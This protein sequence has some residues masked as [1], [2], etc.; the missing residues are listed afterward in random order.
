MGWSVGERSQFSRWCT[1]KLTTL[2]NCRRRRVLHR[3]SNK[4]YNLSASR[5]TTY[6]F[7]SLLDVPK[8]PRDECN[9]LMLISWCFLSECITC[10]PPEAPKVCWCENVMEPKLWTC[11]QNA[12]LERVCV[13][14][15]LHASLPVNVLEM[16]ELQREWDHHGIRLEDTQW[17]NNS[18]ITLWSRKA[19]QKRAG[20]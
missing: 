6:E 10:F 15:A 2:G 16:T 8:H 1:D 3:L 11:L 20:E 9:T 4:G 7:M 18:R 17:K 13:S 12:R 19:K 5:M 14:R